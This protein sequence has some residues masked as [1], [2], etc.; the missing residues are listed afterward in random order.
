M[1]VKL[2]FL[3][4]THKRPEQFKRC[5]ESILQYQFPFDIEILVNNDSNDIE[6]IQHPL[7]SYFYFSSPDLSELYKF[8]YNKASGE[9]V[10]YLEDDDILLDGF[11]RHFSENIDKANL[12]FCLFDTSLRILKLKI[13]ES[14]LRW[15]KD[16][17]SPLQDFQLS[18]ML[19]KKIP[20]LEFPSGN[21]VTN[22]KA[23]FYNVYRH[24]NNVMFS[25]EEIHYKHIGHDNLS[26]E[27]LDRM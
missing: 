24:Y 12:H 14:F 20:N 10:F 15:R 27:Y 19:F 4:L 1:A 2:S 22:D 16:Q 25:T 6:E 18:Q 11:Y 7:I 13:I 9:Y 26:K 3:V 5:I 8:L 21:D 23:L 17:S